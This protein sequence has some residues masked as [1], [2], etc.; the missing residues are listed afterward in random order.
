MS[1]SSRYRVRPLRVF[2]VAVLALCACFS[3]GT[4]QAQQAEE[5]SPSAVLTEAEWQRVNDSVDLALDWLISQ[6][7]SDG[8]FPSVPTGQP[9]ATGICVLAFLAQGHLPGNGKYGAELQRAVDYIV[10]CQKPYGLLANIAPFGTQMSRSVNHDVGFTAAYNH[11]IAGL[12]LSESYAMASR[13]QTRQI[14]PVIESA[15]K[16]SYEMHDWPKDRSIDNGG[17]RYL[18]NYDDR[19]SDLSITGWQ[20]MFLRSAKNAGFEVPEERIDR[21]IAYVRRCFIRQNGTFTYA[22]EGRSRASRGMSGAGILALAH[23]G[24]HHTPEAQQAGEWILRAGFDN[25]NSRG[26]VY[27]RSVRDDRYF[28]GLLTCSQAMYQLGDRYWSDFF[29]PMAAELIANQNL[30]GSWDRENHRND[31]MFGNAYTTAI[32]VL[33]L[34]ASNQLLPIFQR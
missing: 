17:W 30:D 18:D 21:A 28:Y 10:S 20:L 1:V 22:I 34:S 31:G 19:D 32:G 5:P 14:E 16:A 33:A 27:D 9:G 6:Q 29:P 12:V 7:N 13:E 2:T 4:V 23:S 25:Y 24:L 11:A 15:L 8:Q 26:Q 3:S